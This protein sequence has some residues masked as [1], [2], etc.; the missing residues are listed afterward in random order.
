MIIIRCSRRFNN[1]D[2]DSGSDNPLDSHD[3]IRSVSLIFLEISAHW[4][5]Y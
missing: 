5:K 3:K 2:L 1:S 4:L